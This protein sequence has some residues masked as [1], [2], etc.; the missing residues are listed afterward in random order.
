MKRPRF[1]TIQSQKEMSYKY[2]GQVLPNNKVITVLTDIIE[3]STSGVEGDP[4]V[5]VDSSLWVDGRKIYSTSQF[6]MRIIEGA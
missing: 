2:R 5:V 1:E 4:T 6:G 3:I